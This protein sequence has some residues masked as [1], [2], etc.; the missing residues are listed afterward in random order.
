MTQKQILIGAVA[1]CG[2]VL[3][4]WLNKAKGSEQ[5]STD[6][7]KNLTTT[8]TGNSTPSSSSS[9]NQTYTPSVQ[10]PANA[11]PLTYGTRGYTVKPKGTSVN[12]RRQPSTTAE[13]VTNV[14]SGAVVGV[15]TGQTKMLADGIWYEVKLEFGTGW[16]RNDVIELS[17]TTNPV[18]LSWLPSLKG[19][20]S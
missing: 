17:A 7:F 5:S 14:K 19:I 10:V 6:V 18:I 15:T 20:R 9:T 2:G 11:N 12:V 13:I 1:V 4:Y 16:V 3:L 8:T